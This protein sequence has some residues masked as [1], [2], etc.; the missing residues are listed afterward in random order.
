MNF[1]YDIG[2]LLPENIR[3]DKNRLSMPICWTA[4]CS[5]ECCAI[6]LI[7]KNIFIVIIGVILQQN[8]RFLGENLTLTLF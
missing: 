7:F 4:R 5:Q 1:T 6:F 3:L 2:F 8:A